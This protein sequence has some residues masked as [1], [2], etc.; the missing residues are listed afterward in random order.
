MA[1]WSAENA[2]NAYLRA[3]KMGERAK[4]PDTAE[5]ISA[6]VAGTN[7]RLMVVA[8]AGAADFTTLALVAAAYQTGGQVV[9]I[10]GGA[11]ELQL[12]KRRLGE[13]AAG[14]N[15]VV[16]NAEF[17]LSSEYREAD[18]VVVD[19]RIKNCQ[20]ILEKGVGMNSLVLGYNAFCRGFE[21]DDAHLLPIGEGLLVRRVS[22]SSG[23][24]RMTPTT[25]KDSW[26]KGKRWVVRV[27]KFTGEE[28]VF[29]VARKA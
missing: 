19:C 16:G 6:L 2:T 9:C 10:V 18:C 14:V 28:H 21:L 23:L 5:F 27:D 29:R 12:S 3:I 25:K 13:S 20:E 8:C 26:G 22:S 11:A 17:L 15:F 24:T 7:A 1:A 4:E